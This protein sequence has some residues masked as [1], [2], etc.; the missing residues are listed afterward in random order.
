MLRRLRMA[1][2]PEFPVVVTLDFHA[3]LSHQMVANSSAIVFYQTNPHVD[4]RQRG[5]DAAS[6]M[7]RTVRGDVR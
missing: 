7:A 6:I 5:L 2:G 1:F 4:Q 3:N